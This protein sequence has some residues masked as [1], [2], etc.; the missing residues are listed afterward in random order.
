MDGTYGTLF[1]ICYI[2]ATVMQFS[3]QKIPRRFPNMS[4]I[5]AT[6]SRSLRHRVNYALD[7]LRQF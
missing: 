3:G 2:S 1:A 5:V 6:C 4:L 7:A